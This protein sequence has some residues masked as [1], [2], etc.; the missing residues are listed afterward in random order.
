MYDDHG[1][2]C[3]YRSYNTTCMAACYKVA[4]LLLA[5]D[6]SDYILF[7]P[8]HKPCPMTCEELHKEPKR[9]V[10]LHRQR[11]Q[12]TSGASLRGTFMLLS[13]VCHP[14]PELSLCIIVT[15]SPKLARPSWKFTE[16]EV[17]TL[18]CHQGFFFLYMLSFSLYA[19]CSESSRNHAL[20]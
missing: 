7:S 12:Q 13:I 17:Y 1:F 6:Y 10:S 4:N 11:H 2:V 8:I 14:S 20:N 5:L 9:T 18:E 15:N 16:R 19:Y 3:S